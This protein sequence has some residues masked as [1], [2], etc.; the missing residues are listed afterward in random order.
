MWGEDIGEVGG[1]GGEVSQRSG[2]RNEY[3]PLCG[4]RRCSGEGGKNC[5]ALWGEKLK[6]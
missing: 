5:D 4:K 2:G 3:S 1:W 6:A